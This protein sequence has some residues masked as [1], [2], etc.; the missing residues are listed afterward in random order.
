MNATPWP[1]FETV[2]WPLAPVISTTSPTGKI[3]ESEA[4]AGLAWFNTT[5]DEAVTL[6]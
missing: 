2:I 6:A 1:T 4:I 3:M 5:R